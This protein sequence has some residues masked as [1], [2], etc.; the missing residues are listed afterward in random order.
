MASQ[1]ELQARPGDLLVAI[2]SSGRSPNIVRGA[3]AALL[4]ECKV[5]TL[6]GFSNKNPLRKLGHVNLYTPSSS[7]G[8]VEI[9][10]LTLCHAILDLA[11]RPAGR[12]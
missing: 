6:S 4:L 11:E 10:H 5:V 12:A 8:H 7:F 3:E 9:S 1:I 2:S